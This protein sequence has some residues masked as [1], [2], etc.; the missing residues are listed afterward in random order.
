M[1]ASDTDT[2]YLHLGVGDARYQRRS[3]VPYS[4]GAPFFPTLLGTGELTPL[5]NAELE[6]TSA[7][8][9]GTMLWPRNNTKMLLKQYRNC[10]DCG[11]RRTD[12]QQ[13]H[14]YRRRHQGHYSLVKFVGMSL[15]FS[16]TTVLC[17]YHGLVRLVEHPLC[18]KIT[19]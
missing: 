17:T 8:A 13:C 2:K 12:F 19:F 16:I 3:I 4:R 7:A 10:R 1:T 5:R 9:R 6:T 14:L 18:L 15:L 11:I